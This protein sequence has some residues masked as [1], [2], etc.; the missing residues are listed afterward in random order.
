MIRLSAILLAVWAYT[1]TAS[2]SALAD[3]TVNCQS[4]GRRV[5]AL[6]GAVTESILALGAGNR[7]VGRD[8]TSTHPDAAGLPDVGYYRRLASEGILSLKPDLILAEPDAGPDVVLEQ[9]SAAGVCVMRMPRGG[10]A[11][12]IAQRLLAVASAL[13]LGDSGAG[14]AAGIKADMTALSQMIPPETDRPKILFL[15]SVSGGTPVAAGDDTDAA[16]VIDLIGGKN[17]IENVTGYKPLSAEAAIAAKPDVILMMDHVIPQAGGP[18]AVLALPQI[19]LT[20]AGANGRLVAIDGLSTL[21]FGPRTPAALKQLAR[22][23]HGSGKKG[24]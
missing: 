24:R 10:S 21:G 13:G 6:G 1:Q 14:L 20:P 17:A 15:L 11:D 22:D 18:Q 16:A 9:V 7:M 19:A 12:A 4:A 5:V 23:I 2:L 3:D 8:T